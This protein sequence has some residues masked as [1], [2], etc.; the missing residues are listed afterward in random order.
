MR[1]LDTQALRDIASGSAVLGT[2][3]GGDPYIGT[4]AALRNAE[5]YGFPRLM[6]ADELSE[7]SV[8]VIPF[9]IGSPV[10][11]V[12]KFPLGK[13]LKL[14]Y[15]SLSRFLDKPVGAVMPV[16]IGGV[17][18]M[19]PLALGS[20]LNLPVV[21]ADCMGRAFPEGQLVTLT[22]DGI[23]TSPMAIADE[24]G[25]A[26]V[27]NTIDNFWVERFGRSLAVDFGAIAAGVGSPLTKQ[28]VRDST[29]LGSLTYAER[30]GVAI[31]RAHAEKLDGIAAARDA[32]DGYILFH[33]KIVDVQRR[34][35]HGWTLGEAVLEGMDADVGSQMVIRFQNENLVAIRDGEIIAMVPDLITIM[36]V[37][38]GEAITTEHLQY[39]FRVVV[40]GI[41]CDAKWRTPAGIDLAGPRHFGY[42]IEYE[43][44]ERRNGA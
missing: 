8:V 18:S 4:L 21:D 5:L 36:D 17:N 25:N 38:S 9:M 13:E 16:E 42:D 11:L 27:L 43:P 35:E 39:G 12:E 20:L 32:T 26:I 31:R 30:I 15:E 37:E 7:D 41:R 14:A 6:S 1:T 3:G 44:I 19:V 40:L 33:G 24:R 23:G 29:I 22:L 28:Q 10:P 2:G 34:I